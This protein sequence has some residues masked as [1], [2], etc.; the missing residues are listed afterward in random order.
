[1]DK[2]I[3]LI[4]TQQNITKIYIELIK[5]MRT[6]LYEDRNKGE[7]DFA[8]YLTKL[9]RS[10][11]MK[12][13]H[14]RFIIPITI[15]PCKPISHDLSPPEMRTLYGYLTDPKL[16]IDPQYL[17]LM[18]KYKVIISDYEINELI[19]HEMKMLYSENMVKTFSRMNIDIIKYAHCS[20]QIVIMDNEN[21][22]REHFDKMYDLEFEKI[23]CLMEKNLIIAKKMAHNRIIFEQYI[24]DCDAIEKEYLFKGDELIKK[25]NSILPF[26]V[27][28]NFEEIKRK[29]LMELE[30]TKRYEKCSMFESHK[31]TLFL[32]NLCG[33]PHAQSLFNRFITMF[34]TPDI[35]NDE[36]QQKLKQWKKDIDH[37]SESIFIEKHSDNNIHS[38]SF[39]E[40]LGGNFTRVSLDLLEMNES[41]KSIESD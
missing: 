4:N 31:H 29:E 15:N 41:D 1:M 26:N 5:F 38:C 17:L 16:N 24:I 12:E 39:D 32:K 7:H 35:S 13:R 37:V 30:N 33:N 10:Y 34:A 18:Q 6:T 19:N 23:K 27:L 8:L 2:I 21:C 36:L 9:K 28:Q 25:Y 11:S 22:A 40:L 3:N 14:V 20:Q